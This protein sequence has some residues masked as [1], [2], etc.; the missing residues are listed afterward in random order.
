MKQGLPPLIQLKKD[1]ETVLEDGDY[2]GLLPDACWFEIVKK[3]SSITNGRS[4][5]KT[6]IQDK[7]ST[8]SPLPKVT[9][10]ESPTSNVPPELEKTKKLPLWMYE[11]D[12]PKEAKKSPAKRPHSLGAEDSGGKKVKTVSV[13]L[14]ML[15]FRKVY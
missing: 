8:S 1:E 2:F 5:E 6:S 15:C 9:V 4:P 3:D 14:I 13:S 10:S 11:I 12:E 7:P